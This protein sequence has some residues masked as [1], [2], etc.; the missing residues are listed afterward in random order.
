LATLGSGRAGTELMSS[1]ETCMNT[2]TPAPRAAPTNWSAD[3]SSSG[4]SIAFH[5]M[6]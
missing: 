2:F 1:V 5:S 6:K 3:A 4:L